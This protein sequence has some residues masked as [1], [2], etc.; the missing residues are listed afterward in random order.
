MVLVFSAIFF[1]AG[2]YLRLTARNASISCKSVDFIDR[3]NS[4][5]FSLEGVKYISYFTIY[6]LLQQLQDP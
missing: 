4:P 2:P 1:T 3:L 6:S 5:K